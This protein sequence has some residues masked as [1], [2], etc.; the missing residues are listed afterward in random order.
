M[1][2]D[3]NT[4]AAALILAAARSLELAALVLVGEPIGPAPCR[5]ENVEPVAGATFGAPVT[6]RCRD[7]GETVPDPEEGSAE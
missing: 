5:H 1:S 3:Q 4:R 6:F 7:C 2:E